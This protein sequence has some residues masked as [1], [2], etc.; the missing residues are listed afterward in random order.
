MSKKL[1]ESL[2][3]LTEKTRSLEEK[4]ANAKIDIKDSIKEKISITTANLYAQKDAFIKS[5]ENVKNNI[6]SKKNA[7][8]DKINQ[9]M[10]QFKKELDSKKEEI[11]NKVDDGVLG[12]KLEVAELNYYDSVAYANDCVQIAI[13]A[14][15]EVE[16]ASLEVI[17]AKLKL[18]ELKN[19]N[20]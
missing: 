11:K 16:L 7:F 19:L 10:G 9:K 6:D 1:S 3:E 12:F 18:E 17:D 5:V 15:T 20:N 13:I 8:S 2:A 14:L 4:V